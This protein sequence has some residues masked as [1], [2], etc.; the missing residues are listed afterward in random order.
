MQCTYTQFATQLL[1]RDGNFAPLAFFYSKHRIDWCSLFLPFIYLSMFK[2]VS[3]TSIYTFILAFIYIFIY[4]FIYL[5][6]IVLRIERYKS[7]KDELS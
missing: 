5:Y 7:A 1:H 6:V 2:L 4:L 3:I